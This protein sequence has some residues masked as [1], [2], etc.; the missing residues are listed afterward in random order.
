METKDGLIALE[1]KDENTWRKWLEE[2]H[3]QNDS[4]WL[5]I[6]KKDSGVPSITYPVAVDQALCFGWVDSKPNKRDEQSYYQLFSKR[7]PKSNWSKVNKNKVAKLIVERKMAQP[8]LKMIELA[9]AN[10]TWDALNEVD[11]L[12]IPEDLASAFRKYRNASNNFEGFPP[13]VKRGILEWILNAKKPNTRQKRINETA[14]LAERNIRANQ[15][16]KK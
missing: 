12:I 4:V 10:G 7:N 9:K 2:N 8:G 14:E 6:Y 15:F 1:A 5:I 3:S 16:N 11:A 13:S